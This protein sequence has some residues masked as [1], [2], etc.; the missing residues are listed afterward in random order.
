MY[1]VCDIMNSDD[2]SASALLAFL[3]MSQIMK[4]NLRFLVYHAGR[5][6]FAQIE[7]LCLRQVS[8]ILQQLPPDQY[9]TPQ[10]LFQV[11]D[12]IKA[13]LPQLS[14]NI[15]DIL[16]H[17]DWKDVVFAGQ[18]GRRRTL[19]ISLPDGQIAFAK[20]TGN[21]G[22]LFIFE[23]VGTNEVVEIPLA[24]ILDH[25][26]PPSEVLQKY[27]DDLAAKK[28][29]ELASQREE[30]LR[31]QDFKIRKEKAESLQFPMTLPRQDGNH[32][33]YPYLGNVDLIV[34]FCLYLMHGFEM[35]FNY[36]FNNLVIRFLACGP[37]EKF[38]LE[39][40]QLTASQETKFKQFAENYND[41]FM[42]N[43]MVSNIQRCSKFSVQQLFRFQFAIMKSL[44]ISSQI[45]SKCA[46]RRSKKYYTFEEPGVVLCKGP[47]DFVPHSSLKRLE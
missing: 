8:D 16:V 24:N 31:C 30:E 17:V 21:R 13:F 32:V 39:V 19:K 11:L 18:P 34:F 41:M 4:R 40:P 26:Q 46:L 20:Y 35:G 2:L 43:V 12:C 6:H 23:V 3:F 10:Q 15:E 33:R 7:D 45:S 25:T 1:I 5:L 42:G 9:P 44:Q 47:H 29:A 36:P 28:A 22:D 37:Q 14:F 38:F 27:K